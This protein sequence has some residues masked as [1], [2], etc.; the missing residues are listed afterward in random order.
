MTCA[1]DGKTGAKRAYQLA[2][3]AVHQASF[4][5]ERGPSVMPFCK[6][7]ISA[8]RIEIYG[9]RVSAGASLARRQPLVYRDPG[10]DIVTCRTNGARAHHRIFAACAA[11]L[12]P[13][14]GAASTVAPSR[15]AGRGGN[16]LSAARR[17]NGASFVFRRMPRIEPPSA[18]LRR[19]AACCA[20]RGANRAPASRLLLTLRARIRQTPRTHRQAAAAGHRNKPAH[21]SNWRVKP[22]ASGGLPAA[23][24]AAGAAAFIAT[25]A[26]LA[27]IAA[28][29]IP[30]YL[31]ASPAA[32][33]SGAARR[34]GE[35]RKRP[36]EEYGWMSRAIA[37]D[38]SGRTKGA[39]SGGV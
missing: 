19:A 21:Q 32:A 13:S 26:A 35:K 22:A 28:Q 16:G 7:R 15:T 23:S 14:A 20:W 25:F 5:T 34:L 12:L 4:P 24:A 31:A 37:V 8:Q 17:H 18:P 30:E 27:F 29:R 6:A 2:G 11:S 36:G 39:K 10:G 3:G 33:Y 38:A 9:G 1:G